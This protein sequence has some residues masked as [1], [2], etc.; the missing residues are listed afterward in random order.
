M[1]ETIRAYCEVGAG[2]TIRAWQSLVSDGS[3]KTAPDR[4]FPMV[5]VR[6]T[7]PRTDDN[8]ATLAVECAVLMGTKTDDDKDHA[9]VSAL[10]EAVQG[11]IDTLFS[12]FRQGTTTGAAAF[13]IDKIAEYAG[14]SAFEFGGLTFGDGFGPEDDNGIN[15]I[16][17][18]LNVHYSRSDF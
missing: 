11:L 4:A 15:M 10:Y 1:V 18:T 7:P 14:A 6:C 5:D 16:G 8:Q 12:Q 3:W 13:F 2:V 9:V 17:V